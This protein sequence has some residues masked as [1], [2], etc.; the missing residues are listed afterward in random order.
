MSDL[1]EIPEL[2]LSEGAME[3]RVDVPEGVAERSVCVSATRCSGQDVTVSQG[4]VK[5]KGG[6]VRGSNG[7]Q[8]WVCQSVQWKEWVCQGVQ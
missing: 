1:Q 3:G 7:K 2:C 6:C 4:I 8:G 5:R